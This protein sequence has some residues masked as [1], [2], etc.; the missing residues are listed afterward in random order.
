MD[1]SLVR[2]NIG[3]MPYLVAA[4]QILG[5]AALAI[6]GTWL[7]Q[8]RGGFSWDGTEQFNVH[9]LCMVLGMVFL[10]GDALLVFRVFRH[11]TKK[12]TKILHGV[13]H[14][15]ALIISLVGIIAVFQYHKKKNINDMY[16]LHSWLGITTFTLYFLQ[17]ILGFVMFFLPGV[18]FA[19][20]NR[21]KPIHVFL[22]LS[23]LVS[24]IATC[25]LGLT[26]KMLFSLPDDYAK[27][28][29]EGV[30]V[31]SL[32]LLLVAFGLVIAYIVTREEWRRPLLPEEQA[33]SIDFRTLTQGES[34]TEP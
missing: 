33:L 20:K 2:E 5:V 27:L 34:P 14:I 8:Y 10:C 25:L 12:A 31:N 7:S 9:P 3:L 13:L 1:D 11:E 29:A 6:T 18:G 26:E 21:F 4:S 19:Y 16:S 24:T 15:L 32:G 22:G 30:L 17:W 23:L 28:P